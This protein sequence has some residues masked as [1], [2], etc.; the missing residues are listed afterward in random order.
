MLAASALLM[1][2]L[3]LGLY[4]QD[5]PAHQRRGKQ[6]QFGKEQRG[7][8]PPRIPNLTEEQA[9]QLTT[10]KV[11]HEKE[12]LPL[13]NQ[14]NEL[15]AQLQTLMTEDVINKNE[16]GRV[17][18]NITDI[19]AQL[20]KMKI[21]QTANIKSVLTEEQLVAFNHQLTRKKDRQ[22]RRGR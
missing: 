12:A 5:I 8:R 4:A 21:D 7:Q 18:E 1:F 15:E 17:I 22:P 6:E 10:F 19:K 20:M 14:I 3:N 16:A 9:S 11:A 2:T 13:K